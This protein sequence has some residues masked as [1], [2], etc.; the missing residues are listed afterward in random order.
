MN[1]NEHL[2]KHNDYSGVNLV[3]VDETVN[4]MEDFGNKGRSSTLGPRP[5]IRHY[6]QHSEKFNGQ[7]DSEQQHIDSS[8]T[9]QQ[10]ETSCENVDRTVDYQG[11]L[12][13]KKRKWKNMLGKR[14]K[15]R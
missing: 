4:D 8:N 2:K 15:Q 11:W 10:N 1:K 9:D 6:E 14:K 13:L 12:Q 5:I 7:E 3:M